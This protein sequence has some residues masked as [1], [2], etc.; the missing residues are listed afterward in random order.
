MTI[1]FVLTLAGLSLAFIPLIADENPV[2]VPAWRDKSAATAYLG[3]DVLW[4]TS[5]SVV[6]HLQDKVGTGFTLDVTVRD[7]NI[8][9]QGARPVLMW[10]VG[11]DG[12]TLAREIMEDD[13]VVAGNEQ[14]RDGLSDIYFDHRYREWHRTHSPNGYPPGKKRSPFL[15]HPEKLLPRHAHLT[16][17][18][19]GKG[20]YRVVFIASWDH[21]ISITPD[22][23]IAT[24]IH[25]GPGPLYVHGNRLKESYFYA[26]ANVKDIGVSI[27]EE[28]QPFS[29]KIV[30]EDEA[31]QIL[32]QTTPRTFMSFL[33]HKNAQAG[34]YRLRVTGNAPGACLHMGGV[35]AVLCPDAETA[36]MI[37]GGAEFDAKERIIFHPWQRTLYAWADSLK[38][39]DLKV[40]VPAL[41]AGKQLPKEVANVQAILD[42]QIVDPADP[43]YGNFSKG[44]DIDVLAKAAGWKH[45]D[46]IYYGNQAIV[47]RVLLNQVMR[48]IG[49]QGPYFWYK[50][51]TPRTFE[52]KENDFLFCQAYRSAW[53][54]MC[55][56]DSIR[57]YKLL[58]EVLGF[59]PEE[60]IAAFKQSH[61]AWIIA[62]TLMHQGECSN[63]WAAIIASMADLW[64]AT[65]DP[66]VGTILKSQIERF[67]TPGS[68]G[69][70][71][72][73]PTPYCTK[74]S[75]A[76]TYAV[77]L[78]TTGAGYPA[79]NLGH[80]NEYCLESEIYMGRAWESLHDQRIIDWFNKYY[81]LK[82]HLTLPKRGVHPQHPFTGTC[83]PSDSNF[84]TC[85]YTHKS[86]IPG[87][88]RPLIKYGELWTGQENPDITWPCLEQKSFT[89][90]IDNMFFFINTPGYYCILYGGPA[91]LDAA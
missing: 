57:S 38:P 90:V 63:Q 61:L 74:S 52:N 10:V 73:D 45:P 69:R 13:G 60:I 54:G 49:M 77:D 8:Y 87:K 2:A 53:Y 30:L 35:S 86:P 59:M 65:N 55:G 42:N 58:R 4:R 34:V 76:Y 28:I 44:G 29:W 80:D 39:E 56:G 41:P 5:E 62:H 72:P 83:S 31:D 18:A 17:A 12:K 46:N 67:I 50:Y 21:W 75:L 1:K 22:R 19:A 64:D 15:A 9:M 51:D 24:G 3:P 40:E 20:L 27:T 6:F 37:H 7:M 14:Y 91:S 82:T 78:G 36:K 79:E 11:P 81:Y 71:A 89:R 43:N 84:R 26:P 48:N 70:A 85:C 23:P 47:R 88:A 68:L 16:V 33:S 25:P 66:L 32:G